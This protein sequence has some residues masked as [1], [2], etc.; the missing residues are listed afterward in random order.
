MGHGRLHGV[1]ERDGT[2]I[3]LVAR[4]LQDYSHWLDGL[5]TPSRDFH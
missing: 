2:L 1:M 4:H 5:R 3:S